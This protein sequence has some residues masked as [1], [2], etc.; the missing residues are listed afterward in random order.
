M[1][2]QWKNYCEFEPITQR[3]EYT[4]VLVLDNLI[5]SLSDLS[6]KAKNEPNFDAEGWVTEE[7]KIAGFAI[8]NIT[9]NINNLVVKPHW[10]VL[11][12]NELT[13]ARV[14]DFD[15]D[16]I[17]ISGT[18]RDFDLYNPKLIANLESFLRRTTIPVLGI[19]GGHQILGQ[20]FGVRVVT[21]DGL[22]PWEKRTERMREYQYYLIHVLRPQ[23]P[24][25]AGI[26]TERGRRLPKNTLRVWQNHGLMLERV[27]PGFSLLAKSELTR[28][29][30]M[31]KRGDG[32]LLY[33]V[34]FHLEKSFEDW[35]KLPSPWEHRNESRDGRRMFE[36]FLIEALKHRGK[37]KL[38]RE[39]PTLLAPAVQPRPTYAVAMGVPSYSGHN[40][41]GKILSPVRPTAEASTPEAQ[42][43]YIADR[44]TGL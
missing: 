38:V 41:P 37:A 34:Q 39:K 4:R 29:Q 15:P 24:L 17:I 7:R 6:E 31:V 14:A 36:N 32:Q 13:D 11:R 20:A 22:N 30:I 40:A 25:F 28:N 42:S 9:Q 18:L 27:P 43:E 19:C 8:G 33:G 12:L 5:A 2:R 26:L 35:R 16:A 44:L 10:L 3:I 23:D 1:A 21:L